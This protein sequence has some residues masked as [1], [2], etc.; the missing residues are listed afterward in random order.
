[1]PMP[2]SE[3]VTV[4]SAGSLAAGVDGIDADSK[5]QANADLDQTVDQENTNQQTATGAEI[6][7]EQETGGSDEPS[8]Q[9][10]I[11]AE[12]NE[13]DR[14]VGAWPRGL[15]RRHGAKQAMWK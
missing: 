1:M 4:E 2:T 14:G 12:W 5:A 6:D 9:E 10:N 13:L 15:C 3:Y 11:N 7:D 8:R